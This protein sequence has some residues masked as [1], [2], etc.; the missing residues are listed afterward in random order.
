MFLKKYGF[1]YHLLFL[2]SGCAIPLSDTSS[3]LGRDAIIADANNA[4]TRGDCTTALAKMI[5]LYNSANTDNYVRLITA[6]AY[7]CGAGLDFLHLMEE[8]IDNSATLGGSG[9]WRFVTEQFP[10]TVADTRAE[11]ALLAFDAVHAMI[12]PGIIVPAAYQLNT[13]S[14]NVGSSRY[15]DRDEN[16]NAYLPFIAMAAM[17]AIQNRYGAPD[18]TFVK[19]VDLPWETAATVDSDGCAYASAVVNMLDGLHATANVV[20]GSISTTLT[21]ILNG[22][23]TVVNAAC[24]IGCQNTAV[25]GWTQSGCT[26]TTACAECPT[27]LRDK[28]ACQGIPADQVSCAAAGIVNFINN[29]PIAGWN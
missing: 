24:D 4:L 28:T 14:Y 22:F 19:T 23:D 26:V 12:A 27:A 25:P 17:G 11:S 20:Q 9:F 2:L 8:M 7:A 6:S 15:T 21:T 3:Q 1:F 10:S 18:G 5:P 16:A 13:G 29:D